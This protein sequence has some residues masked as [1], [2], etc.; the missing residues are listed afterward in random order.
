MSKPLEN[1]SGKKRELLELMLAQRRQQRAAEKRLATQ[2]DSIPVGQRPA[3]L[4]LSFAQQRLWFLDQLQPGSSAYNIPAGARLRGTIDLG[5]MERCLRIIVER[6]ESLRLNFRSREGKPHLAVDPRRSADLPVVDL[7]HF[8][9]QR[10]EELAQELVVSIGRQPFDLAQDG[11][12]RLCLLRLNE[13]EHVLLFT[14][15]HIIGDVWSIGVFF[16]ELARLYDAF[17]AG[18]PSPLPQLAV[19][20]PDYA[21]WQ[22]EHLTGER[23]EA[24]TTHWL[25]Q[26][27]GAKTVLELPTD[28][29]RPPQQTF[30]GARVPLLV[31]KDLGDRLQ[32]LGQ[33][34]DASIYMV[35][36]GVVNVL[37]YRYTG[38][39]DLLV[40]TPMANRHRTELERLV[41]FF[42]NTVVLRTRLAHELT[43][44]EL[45]QRV[46]ETTLGAYAHPDLPFERLVELLQLER[47]MSRNPLQQ[48]DFAFQNAPVPSLN[49][50][51]VTL[52]RYEIRETTS[53]YDLELDL[54]ETPRG[55]E[56]FICYNVDLFLAAT[57]ER[58][59][60]HFLSLLEAVV[61]NPQRSVGALPL[62]SR[63]QA[64]QLRWEW[65][66]A[67]AAA[68]SSPSAWQRVEQWG[69][70]APQSV[71]L[72]WGQRQWSYGQLVAAARRLALR[73]Q[74]HG[75]APEA[76]V[77]LLAPRGPELVTSVL[78]VMAAGGAWVPLDLA[79]PASRQRQ[80]CED[81]EVE[82]VLTTDALETVAAAAAP[83]CPAWAVD[84]WLQ[85]PDEDAGEGEAPGIMAAPRGPSLAYVIYTSGSTGRPKGVAVSHGALNSYLDW[86]LQAYPLGAAGGV[87]VHSS[88]AFDLTIT[89]LLAPLAAGGTA[90]LVPEDGG[91]DA[92][93]DTLRGS[94]DED[95][96]QPRAAL[97]LTPSHLEA[98]SGLLEPDLLADAV[99]TLILGGEE[100]SA[101]VADRWRRHAPDATVINEYGP[102]EAT[103]GCSVHRLAPGRVKGTAVP[104]GRPVP[105]ARLWVLDGGLQPVPPGAH[106]ELYIAGLGLAR[107]YLGR[108]R[109]TAESF[110]PDPWGAPG[111]RLYRSGDK[112]RHRWDGALEFLGR[113]DRQVKVRGYRIELGEVESALRRQRGV[114]NAAAV[115][116]HDLPGGDGLVGYVVVE[117]GSGSLGSIEDAP[118][119]ALE[120]RLRSALR[121]ELPAYMV[122][123]AMVALE[124]L[125]LTAN[126][127]LD[128][129]A[130]PAPF[131]KETRASAG[132]PPRTEMERSIA[133]IWG[134]ILDLEGIGVESD[135]FDLG[136]QSLLA[137]QVVSRI[138]SLHGVEVP[139]R[140][141]FQVPTVEGLAAKVEQILAGGGHR[142][143]LPMVPVP[144]DGELPL[145]FSQERLWFLDQLLPGNT[146]YNIPGA[147]RMRGRLDHRAMAAAL[148]EI[149]RRHEVLR[150]RFVTESGRPVQRVDAPAPWRVPVVDLGGL[151]PEIREDLAAS[152]AN[153]AC[154]L[155]FDL[156]RGPLMRT[157]LLRLGERE[158]LMAFVI[159]HIAYDMWSRQ[160]FI[161]EL[162]LLYEAFVAGEASPLP[163]LEL[164]YAD[165][166]SWQRRWLQGEV[167]EQQLD[168]WRDVLD[169]LDVLEL[170]TDRPRGGLR[171]L[172]GTRFDLRVDGAT[173]AGLHRLAEQ[174][175]VTFFPVLLAVF[176]TLMHRYTG[177]QDIAVGSPV[178]GRNRLEIEPLLGFFTNTLVLRSEVS[179][180]SCFG[181]L[182]Q[183]SREV[184]LGAQGHQD[185]AFEKLVGELHPTRDLSRQ[186]LFQVMLNFLPNYVPPE[187]DLPALRLSPERV[188]S[189]GVPFD[190]TL[191][192]YEH[193]GELYGALDYSTALFDR[194]T[195]QRMMEHF[196]NLM[197]GVAQDPA[198]QLWSLPMLSA[199]Q[200]HQML[201]EWSPSRGGAPDEG[202]E[203]LHR[204]FELQAQRAPR[205]VALRVGGRELSYQELARR[206][207]ALARRLRR[208]GL[209]AEDG[210]AVHMSRSAE[211]IV[212]LLA[213][214][215]AGA[216]YL[217][218]DPAYPQ[219][220]LSFMVADAGARLALVDEGSA[221]DFRQLAPE[222][223]E[224]VEIWEVDDD[225]A[226]QEDPRLQAPPA[227]R[228]PRGDSPSHWIY[229]SGSTGQP[230]GVVIRHRS[231]AALTRWAGERFGAQEWAGV[232]ASTSI[233]FD[234]S[235]FEIFATLAHGGTV[236]L[237]DHAL[238]LLDLADRER[239]TLINTVPSAMTE[240]LRL[241]ALPEGLETVCLA[242]EPLRRSLVAQ[243]H[244]RGVERVL[245]LYGPSEDT[246]YSTE[247]VVLRGDGEPVIGRALPE[248]GARVMG[249]GGELLPIGALG[250]LG[251][252]GSG[253]ARGYARRPALTAA[254][255]VPDP[256]ADGGRLY[257]TGDLVR[258]LP[259]GRLDLAGRAD[260]QI[261]LRGFRIELGE[262]T[263]RAESLEGIDEA[264]VLAHPLADGAA[265]LVLY[266]AASAAGP[267]GARDEGAGEA[268]SANRSRAL[269]QALAAFLPDHMVPARVIWLEALPRTPNGKVDRGA[270]PA[271][272][273]SA[274]AAETVYVAPRDEV[275][276]RVAQII[277]ELLELPRV[278][279]DDDFFELGGHSLLATQVL[280][281]VQEELE[282]ELVLRDLFEHLTVAHVA[283][284]VKTLR[285]MTE[286]PEPGVV[287][288]GAGEAEDDEFGEI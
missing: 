128:Q 108:P 20:Y 139:L 261:K 135:F 13:Q 227:G 232:L 186:P 192:M 202:P 284:T 269:R 156:S 266:V 241:G 200:Q 39:D 55:Y 109:H 152:L 19:Q 111:G 206:S 181:D 197:V 274:A 263:A 265:Q 217:P 287:G 163:E 1:L 165:F 16:H 161:G 264:V 221:E 97:K 45:L 134:E 204:G 95:P 38:Q 166:A 122:P 281:R 120:R 115:L 182:V 105:A 136:G 193:R 244:E 173:T 148:S 178:A 231:G 238:D 70:A 100:L 285:W 235:I 103:V 159:H 201:R 133:Q 190:F 119:D 253:L 65:N 126:G 85:A 12:F 59:A 46:R 41:G 226:R 117:A 225:A 224:E 172:E 114:A 239:I 280:A 215:R 240:L 167:L 236:I 27:K 61:E 154:Q 160:I 245:N 94:A 18:Q 273:S 24:Q 164:Q 162:G 259:D 282:V 42:V 66:S 188:H 146:A 234:L 125:P 169:G 184:V 82:L 272:D 205:R 252:T 22:R 140:V 258:W 246:T 30:R 68:P 123:E 25:R 210:V 271:P 203:L 176:A 32:A 179:P 106:G 71:A 53:R 151:A 49:T 187:Q 223:F 157:L 34:H 129:R 141:F 26:L 283:R 150:T 79:W 229:T 131:R 14:I 191:S 104:I 88:P 73:L 10:S 36:L 170:P 56:G 116:R 21:L 189:G 44:V 7:S 57:A 149:V 60:Q 214:T 183:R 196:Q 288:V 74:R 81:A 35:L 113:V 155:P 153:A 48:V 4:P 29:P 5:V 142:E 286:D 31:P 243:L 33:Q 51:G 212:A 247:E 84:R 198:A 86:C 6:H 216:S 175:G 17:I 230:K 270:L 23:M 137:T 90:I 8:S 194:S 185:V 50:P 132:T 102:T 262:I 250:E 67:P 78:A 242:G 98:L 87:P 37:L 138:R 218:L 220:R 112:A 171:S 260:H 255:F 91:L 256:A 248:T 47:D 43:F 63:A 110:L 219:E 277:A 257:R 251:L 11:L 54:R 107:G 3:T 28:H 80:V 144:R 52:S 124:A 180:R 62:L 64:H 143:E 76:R 279:V 275:E 195:V 2:T 9:P 58:M 268:S 40:G 199:A 249:P 77:A 168:Y 222:V 145:S 228:A 72:R 99:Q 75:L 83:G 147:V 118:S 127:K 278:G 213:V 15:H 158:H 121:S 174:L 254:G 276:E 130:L 207:A 209:G 92:L 208:R 69:L 89:G 237:V 211:M 267:F 177:R 96:W 93:R 233:C 101:E